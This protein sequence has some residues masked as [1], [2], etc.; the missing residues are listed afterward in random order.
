MSW[1]SLDREKIQIEC[2]LVAP[3]RV[4]QG[5]LILGLF[6]GGKGN[7]GEEKKVILG[8]KNVIL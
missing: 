1:I 3:D 7:F 8:L 2:P 6:W 4:W 5:W